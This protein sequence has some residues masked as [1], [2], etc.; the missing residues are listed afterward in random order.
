[1]ATNGRGQRKVIAESHRAFVD[2]CWVSTTIMEPDWQP[3]R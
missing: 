3:V 1:M 2:Q